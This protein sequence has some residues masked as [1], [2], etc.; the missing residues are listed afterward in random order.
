M[1]LNYTVQDIFSLLLA[2]LLFST[3]LVFPGYVIGWAVNL[4]SF[5]QRTFFAQYVI[6]MALSNALTPVLL[7]L[8][9]RLFSNQH[10]IG[11]I[12]IFFMLWVTILIKSSKENRPR[13]ELTRELKMPIALGGAWVVFCIFQ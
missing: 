10:G 13:P 8:P 2:I 5:K 9:Y 12:V 11:V 3:V 7:F 1:L 6:A 4:F